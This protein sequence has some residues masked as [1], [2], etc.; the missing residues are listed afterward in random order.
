MI[1]ETINKRFKYDKDCNE[2]GSEDLIE[3]FDKLFEK[4]KQS[5]IIVSYKKGGIPS[6]ETIVTLLKKR[7]KK[8]I[9]EVYITNMR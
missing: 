2:F 6:I 5:K 9:L 4:F 7:K 8:Y 1:Y 3:S